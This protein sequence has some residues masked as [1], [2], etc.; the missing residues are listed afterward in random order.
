MTAAWDMADMTYNQ[1]VH[2]AQDTANAMVRAGVRVRRGQRGLAGAAFRDRIGRWARAAAAVTA[3]RRLKVAQVGYAMNDMGDIRFDEGSLLR[4]LGPNISV[5]APG[6][7]Y[8]ATV[9]VSAGEVAEVL[10][11]EDERFEIDPRL[12]DAEREDHA[13]MQVALER[14]MTSAGARRSRPTSTR[15]ART[16]ASPGSRSPPPRA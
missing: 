11:F 5:I 4:A 7:L 8:R 12:S 9:A 6:E 15:S 3:W 16:A 14:L 13:R 1:G 2:G 10:A